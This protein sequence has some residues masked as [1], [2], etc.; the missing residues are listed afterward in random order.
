[1]ADKGILEFL[2][3]STEFCALAEQ[4]EKTKKKEFIETSQKLLGLL[5]LKASMLPTPKDVEGYC[6]AYVTEDDWNFIQSG[7]AQ[8]LGE[9]ETFLSIIEPDNYENGEEVQVSISECFADIYQDVRDF[10][11]RFRNGNEETQEV[12]IYECILNF[13][14][15]WGPR[16][17]AALTELHSF[18]YSTAVSLD[19]EEE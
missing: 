11:E 12:A 9:L 5:Y 13:K 18:V 4:V 14:L 2:T 6:D 1:M 16:L 7:V 10:I 15:Y 19:E 8:K 3:I 17:L